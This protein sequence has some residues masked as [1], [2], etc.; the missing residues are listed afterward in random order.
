MAENSGTGTFLPLAFG[1][2]PRDRGGMMRLRERLDA[3]RAAA[4]SALRT[5]L[6]L[7][8]IYADRWELSGRETAAAARALRWRG[9][10]LVGSE[11]PPS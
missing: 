6:R 1:R 2:R 10:E 3:A 8:E 11:L 7:H 5:Q 4:Q 9:D